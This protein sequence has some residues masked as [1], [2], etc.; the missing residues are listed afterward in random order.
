MNFQQ[1]LTEA[2]YPK[3]MGAMEMMQ[4][5]DKATRE[6]EKEMDDILERKDWESF[7]KLIYKVV[8]IK[9]Q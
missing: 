1:F 4:F 8:G 6:E 9:L 5:Y 3:N 2:S 7:K